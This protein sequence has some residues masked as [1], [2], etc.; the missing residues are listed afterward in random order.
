MIRTIH[1]LIERLS[2]QPKALFLLDGIGAL[3]TALLLFFVL[4]NFS[5]QIGMPQQ[6]VTL[7]SGLALC[8]CCYSMACFFLVK[9]KWKSTLYGI[10]T[11]NLLYCVVTISLSI[12]H[13]S[14]LTGIGLAY[15]LGEAGII[16]GLACLELSV[17]AKLKNNANVD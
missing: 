2:S 12:F 16:G 7:L 17:A 11:A 9:K 1:Q 15:F 3:T 10:G 6:I 4:G 13:F 8:F 14:R 5:D